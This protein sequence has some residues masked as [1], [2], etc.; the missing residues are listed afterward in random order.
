GKGAVKAW[1]V[2]KSPWASYRGWESRA[3]GV[4]RELAG[5]A[6]AHAGGHHATRSIEP[7][8]RERVALSRSVRSAMIFGLGILVV[9]IGSRVANGGL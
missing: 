6:R 5:L 2:Q 7:S 1:A 4:I 9:W 8:A 3:D